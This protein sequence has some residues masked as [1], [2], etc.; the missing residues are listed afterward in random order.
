MRYHVR[1]TNTFKNLD[2]NDKLQV[3]R[4]ILRYIKQGDIAH[5]TLQRSI[6]KTKQGQKG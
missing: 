2:T 6:C 5:E 3:Y 4:R 1:I